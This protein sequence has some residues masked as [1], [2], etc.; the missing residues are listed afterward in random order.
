MG[1]YSSI[2][3]FLYRMAEADEE[4]TLKNATDLAGGAVLESMAHP[5]QFLSVTNQVS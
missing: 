4:P 2:Y 3:F 1:F 5:G